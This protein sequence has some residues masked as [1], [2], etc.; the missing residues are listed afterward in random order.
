M[1][2][3]IPDIIKLMTVDGYMIRVTYTSILGGRANLHLHE[4]QPTLGT[5]YKLAMLEFERMEVDSHDKS[6]RVKVETYDRRRKTRIRR[7]DED[8]SETSP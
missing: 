2:P 1:Y 5:F 4:F 3:S 8:I 6:K 7:A